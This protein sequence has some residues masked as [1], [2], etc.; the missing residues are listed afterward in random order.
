MWELD[1]KEGWAP[2]NWC[3]QTVV[4][5]KTLESKRTSRRL[6]QSILKD[7][8]PE[9]SL[10]WLMLTLKLQSFGHLTQRA[11]SLENTLML[12][13]FEGMITR[14]QKRMN[15]MDGIINSVNKSLSK[16]QKR[17]KDKEA[18][19]AGIAKIWIRLGEWTTKSSWVNVSAKKI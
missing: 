16:L 2:N 13:K 9:Y 18:W 7:N 19:G 3:F 6:N 8:D 10:E 15:W 12:G 4:L 14:G 5:Q 1:Q 11:D 17:V